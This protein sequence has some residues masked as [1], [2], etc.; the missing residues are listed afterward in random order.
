MGQARAEGEATGAQSTPLP[1]SPHPPPLSLG[2]TQPPSLAASHSPSPGENKYL[3]P[4]AQGHMP[5]IPA[6]HVPGDSLWPS[7]P[8]QE[9]A[10]GS[11]NLS[12]STHITIPPQPVRLQ[13]C[14]SALGPATI[15]CPA[16]P[17]RSLIFPCSSVPLAK[18][19][20]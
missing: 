8:T 4:W 6:P 3:E 15:S 13:P 2:P 5:E 19:R 18:G 7:I 1:P 10:G 11:S 20:T 9:Q 17:P 14:Y 12:S 16:L